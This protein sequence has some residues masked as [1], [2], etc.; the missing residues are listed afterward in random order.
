MSEHPE[1]RNLLGPYVMGA[2]DPDEEREVERHL[3]S[4]PSCREEADN[5]RLAHE[6]LV[7]LAGTVEEP[8]RE[9]KNRVVGGTSRREAR[10]ETRRVPL[11]AAAAVLC[12]LAV[13]GVLYSTGFFAPD[14]VAAAELEATELAPGAGGELRVRAEDP[15]AQAELE[16]WDLP[17]CERNQYYELWFAE[18]GGRVSAGTFT[19]DEAGREVLIMTVPKD[20]SGYDQ[21]GIT[22][23]EFPEEPRMSAAKPVLV[24]DLQES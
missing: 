11:V 23:E 17:R 22:L 2:L 6:R 20:A 19:V 9:L 16:V 4:C 14:E 21:V 13:L 24:G 5:L 10:R 3:E 1:I 7:D 15:N 12:V 18:E 8:P